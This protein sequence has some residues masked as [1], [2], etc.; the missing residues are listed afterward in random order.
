MAA[1]P[2]MA[3]RNEL[4]VTA[5]GNFP[6]NSG[7]DTGSSFAVGANYAGRMFHLPLVS[8]YGEI[9]LV[10]ATHNVQK[11]TLRNGYTSW[12]LT[13]GLKLKFAPEFPLSPYVAAGAGVARFHAT[14]GPADGDSDTR[15]V[16]DWAAGADIKFFP[17]L[18][19]RGEVRDFHAGEPSFTGVAGNQHDVAVQLGLVF[20]F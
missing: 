20:R 12:F 17:Y 1:T 5:G 19:L 6:Q 15:F 3:Q 11:L 10:V 8:L 13:P 7:F 2:A 9:P 16:W 18:S 4:A 14:S